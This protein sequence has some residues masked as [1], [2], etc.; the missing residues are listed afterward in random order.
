MFL[1]SIWFLAWL[2][3]F[4]GCVLIVRNSIHDYLPGGTGLFIAD[5]GDVGDS[6]WWRASLHAHIIG[7]IVCLFAAMPQF[8]KHLIRR[9][10]SCHRTAGRIY[11]LS[12]IGLVAPTGFH[13]ALF[14]KGGFLGKFGFLTLA[15]ATLLTTLQG[16]RHAMSGH[17]DITGHR[18]WMTRSFALVASAVSFRFLHT[19]GHLAGVPVETNYVA[20]LWLSLLGNAAVAEMVIRLRQPVSTPTLQLQTES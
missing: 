7:G 3:Y 1:R 11:G 10:P 6:P 20:C 14:A 17:R 9:F 18:A 5:K 12:V 13:L 15:A 19:I 16:W 8:S 2:A 4:A